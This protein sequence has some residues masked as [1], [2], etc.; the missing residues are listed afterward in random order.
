MVFY[1]TCSD[2]R[3][4][5]YMGR[6]KY[7]NESL[8]AYGWPEDLWFHVDKLSSAHVYLRL[9]PDVGF[10]E[11]PPALVEECAQLTKLN[12]IE[13]C[14]LNNVPI[15]YTPWA[16][17]K[18]TGDMATGQVGFH[19]RAAVRHT[20]IHSRNNE[21]CNRL[22]KTKVEKHNNP[23][24]LH[25][26]REA[27]FAAEEIAKQLGGSGE[28]AVLENPGQSNH[29]LRVTAFI[30]YMKTHYPEMKLVGRQASNQD[31]N[32]AYQAVQAMLQAN[33]KLGALWIPE[34]G[35]AEGAVAAVLEAKADVVVMHADVTPTT[36]EHIKAGNV[37]MAL[38]PN[39]GMQGFMGF[40][41]TFMAAHPD[42]IDPFNDYKRSGY[43][44]M[45]IPFIDNGFAVITKENAEDFDLNA[46]MEGRS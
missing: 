40:V 28:Y 26:A 5:I 12:S 45:G 39:Q 23:A 34:A 24:E 27:K 21:I 6:D 29:D 1:F 17:L 22:N 15:V 20:T 14:K 37:H 13:G 31:A 32:R 11:V 41:A 19:N 2:P 46:Y 18:K 9:P 33:P 44:P 36:L 30:D 8:I 10:D 4:T 38:N 7:E 43:N 35:S 42:M 3:Y 25:D 16:N